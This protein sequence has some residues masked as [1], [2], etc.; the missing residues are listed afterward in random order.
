ME[1]LKRFGVPASDIL[2]GNE[3]EHL[4]GL[5]AFE[6]SRAKQ[7]Y[8]EAFQALP[9][10]DRKA[11]RAGLIMAAIYRT[12]LDEIERDGFHVLKSRTS[13][14]PLRKFW[15]AWKTYVTA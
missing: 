12:L 6:A 13:L 14:T 2:N 3:T 8:Q 11:Q 1:D 7:F 15:I 4:K 10:A 5:L 9:S